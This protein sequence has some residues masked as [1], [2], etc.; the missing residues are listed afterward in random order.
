MKDFFMPICQNP[1]CKEK[2]TSHSSRGKYCKKLECREIKY[3]ETRKYEK[4]YHTLHKNSYSHVNRK[5]GIYI[6]FCLRCESKFSTNN[7]FK[8]L[9]D[10][11]NVFI[12]NNPAL[13]EMSV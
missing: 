8:R 6:R 1:N 7:K 4:E 5:N 10:K 12:S 9:C 2:F 11:C 13:Q 3:Q